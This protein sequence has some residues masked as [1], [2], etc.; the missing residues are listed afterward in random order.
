MTFY[1]LSC[2]L[3]SDI[4]RRLLDIELHCKDGT[5]MASSYLLA[6]N[7]VVF[8]KMLF[9]AVQ[10]EESKT[11]IVHLD[12]VLLIDMDLL[13]KFYEY[14]MRGVADN[15]NQLEIGSVVSL[16]SIAHRYEFT[17]ALEALCNRL[18]TVVSLPTS[19]K[20]QYA[21]TLQLAIVLES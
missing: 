13:L 17:G 19:A 4:P 1:S 6:A 8:E 16:I 18:V 10:M 15:F 11:N 20:L 5:L 12:D 9:S 21:D 3:S 2:L 7:S 14:R